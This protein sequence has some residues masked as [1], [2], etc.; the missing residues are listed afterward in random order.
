MREVRDD[1][2]VVVGSTATDLAHDLAARG[3]ALTKDLRARTAGGVL[4]GA[5]AV[6]SVLVA[7]T[8]SPPLALAGLLAAG[9]A[10]APTYQELLSRRQSAAYAF[11]MAERRVPAAEG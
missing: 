2:L 8:L 9:A 10:I 6:G 5:L 1:D 4:A 11:W 3:E 7:G